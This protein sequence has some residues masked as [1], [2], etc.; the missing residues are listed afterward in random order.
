MFTQL[1]WKLQRLFRG[2]SDSDLWDVGSFTVEK[3]QPIIKEYV[4]YES[5]HGHSL[6]TEFE[7]DPAAWLMIMKKIEYAF[8]SL[9]NENQ[10]K[11]YKS[12]TPESAKIHYD[13]VDEGCALFGKYFRYM[14][15]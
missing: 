14:W 13:N 15:N 5:E 4:T 11:P 8:D 1:K 7:S 10:G 2:Y 12:D 3:L 9:W 6:P